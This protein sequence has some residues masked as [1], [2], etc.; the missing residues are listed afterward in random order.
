MSVPNICENV[1]R[2]YF[3]FLARRELSP[4]ERAFIKC[5]CSSAIKK[6]CNFSD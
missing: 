2:V 3:F 1:L 6:Y 5:V 4:A